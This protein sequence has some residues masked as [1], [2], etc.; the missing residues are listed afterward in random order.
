MATTLKRYSGPNDPRFATG[1]GFLELIGIGGIGGTLLGYAGAWES[2]ALVK[3]GALLA[4]KAILEAVRIAGLMPPDYMPYLAAGAGIG[5][6]AGAV[7]GYFI[8]DLKQEIHIRGRQLETIKQA[9]KA[10]KPRK[11]A[12]TGVS[13]H[14]QIPISEQQECRHFL[15]LGGSGSGKTSILWPMINQAANRGDKCLIFSFKGDFQQKGDFPFTLLAPWDS[16]SA[17]WQLGR[18]IRTRLHAES[19]AKTLIPTPDR[20]PIW[21]QGAQGLLT[22]IISEVQ[23]K[24]GEKWGFYR[25]AQ[26]CSMALSDYDSLVNTVMNES[27]LARSFLMGKD[28][29]TTA[30]YLAQM[31]SN[32]S[33]IINLGVADFS[34]RGQ[35]WS[36][37]D[38]L[39]G[40]TPNAAILGYLPESENL[41]AAYCSSIIEQTVKQI[42]SFPDALPEARRMWLFLDE[43]PQAG[44]IPSIT[45]AL[46]AARSKGCRVVLGMQ[47]VA[48][49]EEHG[50]SKNT[51]RIWAGQCGVK[52]VANLSDPDDQKWAS[53]LLGDRDLERYQANISVNNNGGNGGSSGQSGGYQRATEAVMLP[54]SFGTDLYVDE[55]KNGGPQALIL[56]SKTA[57]IIK[58]PFP[59]IHEQ[60]HAFC[61]ASWMQHGFQRP[62]WGKTPP[63]VQMPEDMPKKSA[64]TQQNKAKQD[65][66][67]QQDDI[68]YMSSNPQP[69]IQDTEDAG[70]ILEDAISDHAISAALDAALTGGAGQLFELMKGVSEI[71]GNSGGGNGGANF[72]P[73]LPQNQQPRRK[74]EDE[75]FQKR[76]AAEA[77]DEEESEP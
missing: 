6:I 31:A 70:S 26:A 1:S 39:A 54:A 73:K 45:S 37:R 43:V 63:M 48:Q 46:E 20:D 71:A 11:K 65:E 15:L 12:T 64:N 25:L 29:K 76:D 72:L 24:Y 68:T 14:P 51:L 16:R 33:D 3:T 55:S 50:Y 56:T 32:L 47:G 5:A 58:W 35:P 41:S 34:N 7:A 2:I 57:A 10:L 49:L 9:A 75:Y 21:A 53:N 28:S 22:A 8:G 27:P 38:W 74:Q 36:V 77:D 60:R 13:I 69:Q 30:S 17:K 61:E 67:Q 19:L 62:R 52:I 40:K 44:K 66:V 18:D 4:P 42:L 59:E 23:S